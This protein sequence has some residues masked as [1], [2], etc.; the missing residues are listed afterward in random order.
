MWSSHY[1]A[2]GGASVEAMSVRVESHFRIFVDKAKSHLVW[3]IA[4][5]Q[6]L[7]P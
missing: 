5:L 1:Y 7:Y 6:P 2:E 4:K 3:P